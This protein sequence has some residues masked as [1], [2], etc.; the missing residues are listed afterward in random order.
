MRAGS[1][2]R[3][4]LLWSYPRRYWADL[5]TKYRPHFLL[6][7]IGGF[8]FGCRVRFARRRGDIPARLGGNA[9]LPGLMFE[10]LFSFPTRLDREKLRQEVK[11][12][13]DRMFSEHYGPNSVFYRVGETGKPR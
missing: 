3:I 8:H 2:R 5:A 9:F 1:R 13:E 12:E 7:W 11:A 4:K 10:F 6:N